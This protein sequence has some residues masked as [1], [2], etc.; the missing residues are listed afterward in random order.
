M[1]SAVSVA[2]FSFALIKFSKSKKIFYK[3]GTKPNDIPEPNKFFCTDSGCYGRY[4]GAEF[5]S[6]DGDIAHQYSNT[7][8]RIVAD[9]IRNEYAKGNY[10]KADID[11]MEISVKRYSNDSSKVDYLIWCPL[12]RVKTKCEARTGFTHSGGWGRSETQ[13]LKPELERRKKTLLGQGNVIGGVLE[14]SKEHKSSPT[15]KSYLREYW[16]NY[17]HKDYQSECKN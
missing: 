3:S 2:F 15:G 8:Q 17:K 13:D 16:I 12:I 11:N 9:K 14:I 4:V 10:F 6:K 7:F 1:I 5:T